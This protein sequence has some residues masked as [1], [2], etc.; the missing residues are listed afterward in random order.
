MNFGSQHKKSNKHFCLEYMNRII[1][2]IKY[3]PD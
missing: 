3:L 2:A 1:E